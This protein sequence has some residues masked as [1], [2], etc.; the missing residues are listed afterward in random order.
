VLPLHASAPHAVLA[1]ATQQAPVPSQVPS[2]PQGAVPAAQVS[3]GSVWT[4][5]A[6]QVPEGW[7]VKADAHALQPSQVVW[8]QTPSTQ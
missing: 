5:A 8:Q 3:C 7:P 6:A 1:G 4:L 2:G